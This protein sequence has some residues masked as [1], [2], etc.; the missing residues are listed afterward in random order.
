[1][2]VKNDSIVHVAFCTVCSPLCFE[3]E[4]GVAWGW[5]QGAGSGAGQGVGQERPRFSVLS[6]PQTQDFR[7]HCSSRRERDKRAE[8]GSVHVWGGASKSN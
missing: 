8:Y 3:L 6:Y 2:C 5:E 7:A 1:M 4:Q